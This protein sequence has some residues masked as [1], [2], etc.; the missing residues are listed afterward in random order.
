MFVEC[1]AELLENECFF[2]YY[3]YLPYINMAWQ[4]CFI[5]TNVSTTT[6]NLSNT[7]YALLSWYTVHNFSQTVLNMSN[8][9]HTVNDLLSSVSLTASHASSDILKVNL[10]IANVSG[11]I[12]TLENNQNNTIVPSVNTFYH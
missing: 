3:Y 7:V 8:V 5:S 2:T 9:V 11:R 1:I 12:F 6:S 10:S 4:C